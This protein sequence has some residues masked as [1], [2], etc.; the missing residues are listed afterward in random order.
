MKIAQIAPLY[1][2]VPPDLYGGTERIVAHLTDALVDGHDPWPGAALR[3][4]AA[5]APAGEP[6]TAS[7]RAW[8]DVMA[9][10]LAI[11]T[12]LIAL[13][14]LVGAR[15]LLLVQLPITWL[16][17]AMGI[18]LFYVQ[19]QFEH[20]YW[21]PDARWQLHAGGLHGS[22]HFDLPPV[23]RWF[24]ANIG[25]H[26]VH[27]LSATIPSYRLGEVLRDHPELRGTNRLTLGRSLR[28]FRL[29]LWDENASAHGE[30]PRGQRMTRCT[31]VDITFAHA[32][33]LV[34]LDTALL[35]LLSRCRAGKRPSGSHRTGGR[36]CRRR[37]RRRA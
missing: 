11:A 35:M 4:R 17:S 18:W 3:L 24:T 10:N 36:R 22:S 9:S 23:L 6:W 30:L 5:P 2:A 33:S 7:A 37:G 27:H 12:V 8:R 28:C 15:D 21:E 31:S 14:W 29:A 25:V 20:T 34:P 1:E 19:H 13:A 16:A 32:F 26:H